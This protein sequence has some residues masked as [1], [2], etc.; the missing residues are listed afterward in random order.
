M[1]EQPTVT[2]AT[3]RGVVE[4]H[5]EPTALGINAAGWVALSMLVVFAILL[6]QKVP[7]MV[8]K[9]LDGQ[10][11]KIKSQLDKASRLRAEAEAML[12][13]AKQ[14]DAASAGDAAAIVKHAEAE[15]AAM[16]AKAEAD[17]TELVAR[18]QTMAQDQIAAAQRGAIAEVRAQAADAAARA[19][20]SIIAERHGADADK[21]LVDRTIAGLGRLN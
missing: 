15:A 1:A 14:R 11:E 9:M 12:T 6:W 13:A 2:T 7:G 3:T 21:A 17:L 8:A 16:L 20:S 18:R 4:L 5:H 10:I 19:A